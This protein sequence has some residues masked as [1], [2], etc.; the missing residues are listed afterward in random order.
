MRKFLPLI[1]VAVG[2]LVLVGGFLFIRSRRTSQETEE[3]SG[4]LID[5]PLE[6]RPVASL[7]P[8]DDGHWLKLVIEKIII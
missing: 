8:S 1:I 3:D 6:K 4:S 5:V 2:I 7:T